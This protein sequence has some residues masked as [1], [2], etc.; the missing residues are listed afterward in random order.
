MQ[1]AHGRNRDYLHTLL[2]KFG[3]IKLDFAGNDDHGGVFA[4]VRI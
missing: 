4:T 2:V 1:I 3:R